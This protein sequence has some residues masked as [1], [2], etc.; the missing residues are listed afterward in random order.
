MKVKDE[1]LFSTLRIVFT[2]IKSTVTR[3]VENLRGEGQGEGFPGKVL[4]QSRLNETT[5]GSG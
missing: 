5:K 2:G 3:F 1:I 4:E